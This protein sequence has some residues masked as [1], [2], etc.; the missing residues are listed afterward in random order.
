LTNVCKQA[1]L[2]ALTYWYS[3]V[4]IDKNMML[5]SRD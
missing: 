5:C 2:L 3:T 1:C 4:L